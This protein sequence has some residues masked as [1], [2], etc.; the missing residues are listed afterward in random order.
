MEDNWSEDEYG[1]EDDLEEEEENQDGI[2]LR[3]PTAT[4]LNEAII[5]AATNRA[6]R[7][8]TTSAPRRP[9][10]PTYS[11][12]TLLGPRGFRVLRERAASLV[13][14]AAGESN[15]VER[16]LDEVMRLY[17]EWAHHMYPTFIFRDF[18]DKTE[19]LC[20]TAPMKVHRG[21]VVT[22]LDPCRRI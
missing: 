11:A 16:E 7:N 1:V 15:A 5:K 22:L 14:A 10:G 3:P 9:R 18:V 19:R 13:A 12:D 6:V 8:A 2:G 4:R 20:R 21:E 17:R